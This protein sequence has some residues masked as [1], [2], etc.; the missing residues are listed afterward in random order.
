MSISGEIG[1]EVKDWVTG[2]GIFKNEIEDEVAEWHYVVEFPLN[3]GQV[4][5]IVMPKG[6][7]MILVVSGLVFAEEHYKALHSLPPKKKK[8]VIFRWKMDLLFRNA[9]F[10]MLPDDTSIQ[11][12]DFSMPVYLEELTKSRLF[13]ALR[14]VFKCKLYIIWQLNHLFGDGKT[15]VEAMYL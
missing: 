3:S 9:E 1:R 10:R 15:G 6:K 5:D 2:E 4:S 11:R 7:D 12:I 14:E 13:E 8:E